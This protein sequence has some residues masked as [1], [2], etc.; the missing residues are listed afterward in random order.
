METKER[1]VGLLLS[2]LKKV[3]TLLRD[4]LYGM[5]RAGNSAAYSTD[6]ILCAAV[7]RAI[8][9]VLGFGVLAEK[10]NYLSALP[11]VRLQLDNSLRCF[12]AF[13]VKNPND[14]VLHF[15]SGKA[16]KDYQSEDGRKMSDNYLVTKLE[17]IVPGVKRVY[18]EASNYVHLSYKHFE[19]INNQ[20]TIAVGPG[21]R[22]S[23]SEK[24]GF[25]NTMMEVSHIMIAIVD[26]WSMEKNRLANRAA[27]VD[28]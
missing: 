6:F 9:L 23:E 8:D 14:F 1:S 19:L 20:G 7:N 4:S 18:R 5:L 24:I 28:H 12:A 21:S 2:E 17:Q 27:S 11:L 10:D 25:V 26:Q 3:E 13:L 16:I 22:F 15:M